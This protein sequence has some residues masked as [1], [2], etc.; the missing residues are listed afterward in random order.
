MAVANSYY[1]YTTANTAPKPKTIVPPSAKAPAASPAAAPGAPPV[2]NAPIPGVAEYGATMA[3]AQNAYD[4]AVANIKGNLTSTLG[5]LGFD[6]NG[7]VQG[8]NLYGAYQQNRREGGRAQ[9]QLAG[10]SANRGLGVFG[11]LA[12]QAR[13]DANY[14]SGVGLS[15][16]LNQANAANVAAKQ[17]IQTEG[18][19]LQERLAQAQ[20]AAAQTNI[21]SRN[22]TEAAQPAAAAT[23]T[24]KPAAPSSFQWAGQTITSK[25]QLTSILAKSGVSYATWAKNHPSAA[26]GLK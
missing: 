13:N 7:N 10:Q 12:D 14:Q 1:G 6:A 9:E 17:G 16:V 5:T 22:F 21:E 20:L 3:R 26:A 23:A 8:E 19:T 4:I 2:T 11:G 15:G 18:T 25:A 24:N